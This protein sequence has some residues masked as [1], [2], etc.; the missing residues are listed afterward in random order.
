MKRIENGG[1]MKKIITGLVLLMALSVTAWAAEPQETIKANLYKVLNVLRDPALQGEDAVSLKKEALRAIS[2]EMFH[3]PLLSRRV[4]AKNW[5]D[6]SQAQQQEFMGLFQD[7]LEQAYIDRI[8]AYKDEQ[9]EYAANRMLSEKKAEV[10]TRI[11][12]DSGPVSLI[13]RLALVGDQWG[14]YD[15]IVE[16]VNLTTNYRNQFR[17]FLA[18]NSPAQLLDHLKKKVGE[19]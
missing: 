11:V 6:L 9:I 17:E 19:P 13:Y 15:V 5:K 3:W 2:N 4:L 10:E 16:G 7:I 14:V 1:N 12:A 18:S 8:L